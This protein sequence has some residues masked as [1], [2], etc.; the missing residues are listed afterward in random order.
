MGDNNYR[1]R[2]AS[3]LLD[4]VPSS[5]GSYFKVYDNLIARGDAHVL[6][7]EDPKLEPEHT[8]PITHDDILL[9]AEILR[10]DPTLTLDQASEQL[11]IRLRTA[12]STRQSTLTILLTVRAML[13][14]EADRTGSG[15]GWRSSECFVDF[16]SRYIP[17]A[18]AMSVA[19]MG[20]L[21]DRKAMKAWKLK[22][23]FNLSFR[24]TDDLARHLLLDPL[25]PDGPTLYLFHHAAFLKSQLKRLRR[26]NLQGEENILTCL[27]TQ[28]AVPARPS[29]PILIPQL[30][31]ISGCFPPRLLAE[32]LHSIQTILF[33]FDDDR[34][35]H[36]LERLITKEGFDEHCSQ[37]DGYN[38]LSDAHQ[39]EYR[40]WGERFAALYRFT[41]ER[42]PRNKLERWMKWQS[43]ESNAFV[44]AV[45][46]LVISILVGILG[47]G[48]ASVQTWIAWEAWKTPVSNDDETTALLQEI[49]E[50]L[51]QQRGR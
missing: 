44:V 22:A 17:K 14:L 27:K 39:L 10:G 45:A 26:Q 34:S 7:I 23:R 30:T 51:R 3:E 43:A 49:A 16:A 37:A 2:I 29:S 48:L 35:S 8:S 21:E 19:V 20:A 15:N 42:P 9:A 1:T 11:R 33:H 28:V 47:L 13:M 6:Q 31:M 5:L 12:C 24:G 40:Y 38:T 4:S 36:I 25:H 18:S 50:L 32:T 46:A 41:H